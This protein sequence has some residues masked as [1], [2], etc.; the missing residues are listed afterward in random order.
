MQI[1]TALIMATEKLSACDD[2]SREASYLLSAVLKKD[3]SYLYAHGEDSLDAATL[4]QLNTWL[5]QRVAGKPLAYLV[6]EKAF[7]DDSF[8]VNESTLIPRPET[9]CL[10]EAVLNLLP[11]HPSIHLADLGTGSGI[12]AIVL[13]KMRAAWQVVAVDCSP[14][15]LSVAKDNAKKIGVDITFLES[16]WLA[17]LGAHSMDVL[18][19][20]P[21][22]LA[23]DDAHL[24]GEIAF[25][26]R[27]A[28]VAGK[29]GLD[30]YRAILK[31]AKRVLKP[32]GYIFLEHGSTQ[33]P[34][35]MA[36]LEV[37][38]F[39]VVASIPDQQ[40]HPR[41]LVGQLL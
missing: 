32:K 10:I 5:T 19:S 28:L 33:A 30:A 39:H 4:A 20:N 1:K 13:K 31:D 27:D 15:A 11:N 36:L 17:A 35:L 2:P 38:H 24:N 7:W 3:R 25:E 9:E 16:D 23:E 37:H 22:Y 18:V 14:Q 21:P 26:P 40:Q 29:D 12:I 8:L 41:I 6:G 34:A